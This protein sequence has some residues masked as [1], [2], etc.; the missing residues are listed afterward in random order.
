MSQPSPRSDQ[1]IHRD[2]DIGISAQP[3]TCK[4]AICRCLGR[5]AFLISD[6]LVIFSLDNTPASPETFYLEQL[7]T[8][9]LPR[10]GKRSSN[11][12]RVLMG[13]LPPT[14]ALV[15]PPRRRKPTKQSLRSGA[16]LG[17]L[18]SEPTI[19]TL[20]SSRLTIP[21]HFVHSSGKSQ[22]SRC[23]NRSFSSVPR[24]VSMSNGSWNV[25]FSKCCNV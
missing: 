5:H 11:N 18:F 25:L 1:N 23:I 21:T 6:C 9:L 14:L 10:R 16:Q 4:K 19:K 17:T 20:S 22:L 12:K 7:L 3:P 24:S 8:S 2:W 13:R 15:M